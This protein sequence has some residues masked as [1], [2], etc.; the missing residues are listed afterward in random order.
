MTFNRLARRSGAES[1][2]RAD[3]RLRLECLEDRTVPATFNV[4]TTLDVIDPADGKRSLREA[5]T[6]ANTLAGADV[7]VLPAGVFKIALDGANE[8]LNATGDFDIS[9]AL[10]VRGAGAGLTV[11][12]AQRKDRLFDAIGSFAARFVDATLRGGGGAN[13]GGAIQAV[14]ADVALVRCAVTDNRALAGGGV[15][16]ENGD[17]TVT[18]S[19]IARN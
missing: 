19:T 12:D 7:I 11:I 15:N 6:A 2:R 18:A 17:V 5:I 3:L 10:T 4:T 14:D 13:N 1:S 9:E 8:N 16:A